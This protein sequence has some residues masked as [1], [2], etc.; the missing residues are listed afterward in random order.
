MDSSGK[1]ETLA[2]ARHNEEKSGFEK[3]ESKQAKSASICAEQAKLA[4]TVLS[5]SLPKGNHGNI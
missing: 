2:V 1:Q 5:L 3:R 4:V